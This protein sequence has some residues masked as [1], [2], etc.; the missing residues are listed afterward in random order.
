MSADWTGEL[1][2]WA[3]RLG[4]QLLGH[5]AW[6]LLTSR[7]GDPEGALLACPQLMVAA[8]AQVTDGS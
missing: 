1:L 8:L 4:Q 3:L 6:P 5:E 2:G 7:P